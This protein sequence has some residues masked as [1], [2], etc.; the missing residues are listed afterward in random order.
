MGYTNTMHLIPHFLLFGLSAAVIWG[1][2]GILVAATDRVAKRYHR[3]GFGVAFFVLGILTSI[4]EI[5]VAA[6]ATIKGVPQISAGNLIGGS[7]VIFLLIIPVLATLGGGIQMKNVLT[8]RSL[9]LVLA[10]VMVPSLFILDGRVSRPEGI[11]MIVTY[12]S[13]F[14]ALEKKKTT[15]KMMTQTAGDVSNELVQRRKATMIDLAKVTVAG[16]LIFIAGKIL[17]DESL[18]FSQILSIPPSLVGL[19]LLS[20]GT[21]APEL[22]IA[23]RCVIGKHKDI[24]FGDYLGSAAANTLIMGFLPLVNGG[25]NVERSEFLS[26]FVLLLAGLTLFFW[27]SRSKQDISRKEGGVLLGVYGLFLV[28]QIINVLRFANDTIA[29]K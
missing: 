26:T 21:N 12:I 13:L 25:F 3:P 10:V 22:V 1:L 27:F 2:S 28:L 29:L 6:N 19:V 7:L 16:A 15:E 14:Y 4:S 9:A 23:I 8:S 24:A 17:V 11:L 5:S 18:F 20:V